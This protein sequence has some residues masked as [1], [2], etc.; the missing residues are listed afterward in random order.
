M[1]LDKAKLRE[2]RLKSEAKAKKWF[3]IALFIT[4]ALLAT[5]IYL[6]WVNESESFP[7]GVL[8]LVVPIILSMYWTIDLFASLNPDLEAGDELIDR[9]NRRFEE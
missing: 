8:I 4:L 6:I 1:A 9:I 2:V 7:V 3:P 5:A